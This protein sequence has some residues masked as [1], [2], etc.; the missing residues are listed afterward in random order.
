MFNKYLFELF[1]SCKR[2]SVVE[3]KNYIT[4]LPPPPGCPLLM[5]LA[6]GQHRIIEGGGGDSVTHMEEL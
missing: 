5:G 3:I 1:S 4:H 6:C 2:P